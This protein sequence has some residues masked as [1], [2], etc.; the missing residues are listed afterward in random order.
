MDIPDEP[1]G[2]ARLDIIR[3]MVTSL[4]ENRLLSVQPNMSSM[5]NKDRIEIGE[6]AILRPVSKEVSFQNSYN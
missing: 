1:G 5:M 2:S 3:T 4:F 6:F